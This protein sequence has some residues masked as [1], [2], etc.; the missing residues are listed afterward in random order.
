M[1]WF[2]V[3]ELKKTEGFWSWLIIIISTITSTLSLIRSDILPLKTTIE[4]SVS[5][6]SVL[7]TLIAAWMKKQAYVERIKN[8]D[9]YIQRLSKLNV[10]M[11]Y[12]LD[13][14]PWDRMAYDKFIEQYENQIILLLSSPPPMSP[15]EFKT[16]VWRLT[17]YYP[18]IVKD[19]YPWFKKKC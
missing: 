12:I 9:R 2:F 7:T 17:R 18:E 5:V 19:T 3:F 8:L 1:N 11:N 4:T 15:E 14:P 6:L 10:E 16:S 13:K